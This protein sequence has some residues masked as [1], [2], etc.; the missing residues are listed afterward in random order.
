M[1]EGTSAVNKQSAGSQTAL[2]SIGAIISLV[3]ASS[4]CL[5]I[6]PFVAAAGLAGTSTVLASLRPYL[7]IGSILFVGYGL[8]QA[9]RAKKCNR[10]TSKASTILLWCSAVL[11][12]LSTL[13]P[14]VIANVLAGG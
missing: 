12:V 1:P 14:Q 10:T 2:A 4:C 7:L 8:Y 9:Y 5:P 11:V 13:F 6:L 3:A